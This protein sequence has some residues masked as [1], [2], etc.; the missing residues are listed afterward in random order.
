MSFVLSAHRRPAERGYVR[1]RQ[2]VSKSVENIFDTFR[3]FFAQ[4][5][6][7]QKPSGSVK[8]ILKYFSRGTSFPAPLGGALILG[9]PIK[10]ALLKEC[11]HCWCEHSDIGRRM[12]W[13][14]EDAWPGSGWKL[15][16]L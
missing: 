6:K 7:R 2:K 14:L 13:L 3:L 4:G 16:D 10:C 1:K 11:S 5:K 8:H 9:A 12:G 15:Q